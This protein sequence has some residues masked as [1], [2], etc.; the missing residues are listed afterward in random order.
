MRP[1]AKTVF[2]LA[3]SMLTQLAWAFDPFVVRDIR[4]VGV[5]RVEPGAVFGYL[6]VRIGERLDDGKAAAAVRALYGTGL[7]NDVRLEVEGEVLVVYVEERPAIAS[8][9][10]SGSKDI[11]SEALLKGLKEIGLAESRIYD[12]ALLERAE[13]EIKRQYLTR[14][15]YAVKITS[16]VT[17]LERNRVAI[18][19]LIDEGADAR[20]TQIRIVGNKAFSE[21]TLLE[22][23]SLTTPTWLSWY[24]KTDQY[25]R[26][27]L[28]GDLE[29]LR[30]YYLNRGYL[31][32]SIDST[33]V[34]ID[35]D[36]EGVYIAV[37]VTE[38]EQFTVT[39]WRFTGNTL[40]R[41]KELE[42]LMQIK[43]GEVF[44]GERL[45]ESTRAITD[46]FGVIG[47]AF[48]NV[49]AIPEVDRAKREVFFNIA[50]D[51]GR[52]SY[53]R[54]INI[55]GNARTRDE[56][57]RREIRQY[58]GAWY[59]ADRIRVSRER[60]NRLGYFTSVSIEP[61]P[62]PD[63]PDQVD[64]NVTIE[65]RSTG[66]FLLGVGFSSTD[67]LVLTASV[68]QQN[69]FGTGKSLGLNINTGKTQ[70]TLVLNSTDPYFTQDGVSRSFDA[71]YRRLNAIDLNLGDYVLTT[72][73]VGLRFGLP[74]TE[75]DRI[76]FGVAYESNDI[77]LGAN[78]P[79]QYVDYVAAYGPNSW[80]VLGVLGWT[81]DNRDSS[82]TPTRGSITTAAMDFT[83]PVG[84]LRYV[85]AGLLH[86]HYFPLTK[87]YTL[88]LSGDVAKGWSPSGYLYPIF[89]N[90]YV[91]GI[92]SVRGFEP[93]SLGPT[94]SAG[95]P[96]GGQAKIVGSA[97][98][99]FPLPGSGNDRSIRLFGFT[100]V[101][102]VFTDR[103][104][105]SELRASA[106]VGLS[107]L[108]PLGPLKLSL[109]W[110]IRREPTDKLQKFQFQIG[111]GF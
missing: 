100:D 33:Q 93:N 49:N 78:P 67:S 16:T 23:L 101:G 110:P 40:G 32:F 5:Q 103:I 77:Q 12:R 30:S 15:K 75:I 89:K 37:N 64:L 14:G 108:S 60:L 58:E 87:D 31:E 13:Q 57:V 91:G 38:G 47:Y 17:P 36:R 69:F 86:Q 59:D 27:K 99:L 65:E 44:S 81:R 76:T 24:T 102:N 8:V 84:D 82:I 43:P 109:G 20:I 104:E 72:S 97:E 19:M 94:N 73:G 98:F 55:S 80:A 34:S 107:W 41:D 56:V 3:A 9:E 53:V 68:N 111:T 52:R 51:P 1:F 92:G 48:A 21:K 4:L 106:G 61:Q 22:Q 39:G 71:F 25:S 11:D 79:S 18:S 42:A 74:Y 2:A 54:R 45:S 28:A 70:R 7:F 85:R 66:Q 90:Y 63:A 83:F 6:P 50:I 62:V 96:I 29:T 95:T 88:A 105:L 46:L 35:P 26:E 10:I